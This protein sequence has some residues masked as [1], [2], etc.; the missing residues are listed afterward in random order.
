MVALPVSH[1]KMPVKRLSPRLLIQWMLAVAVSLL[2]VFSGRLAFAAPPAAGTSIGNQASATYTDGSGVNRT[3]TSNTVQTVVQ[4]VASLT[5]TANGAKSA[6]VGSTVYYPHTLTNTGNGVD[7]FGLSAVNA[8][9][10][11]F[12]LTGIAIFAD[13]GAGLPT[14][15]AI[16]S[17]GAIT[18]GSTFKFIV[19]GTV[20]STATSGSTNNLTVTAESGFSPAQTAT[21]TDTTTVTGNAVINFTKSVSANSGASG[22]GPYTYTLT[23]TNTGNSTATVVKVTDVIPA[24]LTYVASSA[25]SSVLPVGVVLTDAIDGSQGTAPNTIAYDFTAGTATATLAQV[26]SGQSGTISFQVNVTGGTAP[27]V[28]N[29]TATVSYNDGSAAGTTITGTS[30]TVPFSVTQSASVTIGNSTV[31][32]GNPGTA[33]LFTN[34]VTNTGNGTDTFNITVSPGNFPPGT[35][36]V[37]YKS[38]GVTPLVDTNGDGILDTGPLPAGA[39]AASTYNVVVKAVLPATASGGPFTVNVTATSTFDPTKS[40]TGVD[41]LTAVTASSVDLTNNAAAGV[42]GALGTG[43]GP[44]AAAQ[45]TNLT[46][47]GSSTTFILVTKNTGP[48][49]DSYGLAASTDSSFASQTL[50]A[51][52]TVAFRADGG[53]GNCTTTIGGTITTT[54]SVAANASSVVCAAVSVPAGFA[55]GTS[56]LYFRAL[57]ASSGAL[58]RI[59]DAVTVNAVRSLTFTPNN[60]GQVFP[61]GSVVYSHT[62]R[63]TGNVT[64]GNGTLS[65][66]TLPSANSQPGFTSVQY[67]DSNNNGVLDAGDPVVPAGGLQTVLVAGLP[68]GQAITIFDKVIAPSGAAA[69]VVNTTTVT[70]STANGTNPGTKPADA[71]ATDSSTVI[72]GNVTLTKTQRLNATCSAANVGSYSTATLTTGA[73]PGVCIDYQITVQNLGSA[74]ATGVTVSDATPA[75]TVLALAPATTAGTITP[76]TPAVGASGS[77]TATI[78]PL[79]AGASAVVTF[80]VKIQP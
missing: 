34:A 76:P 75:F 24:G 70:A 16:T 53:A 2:L 17:T 57:S 62:L 79:A 22:S 35:S 30:N 20:P 64:E 39:T 11:S 51:G 28:V 46:N 44:E 63:N 15:P 12:N 59:H 1:L 36:F 13:N 45:V 25:R 58:D 69:G 37:L 67:Y 49:A 38:D 72:S 60:T 27:G 26:A 78:G 55:A 71:A 42:A 65:T 74:D 77:I 31:A 47:P 48:V 9:G 40:A 18:S 19:A 21:N 43:A 10:A 41:T 33:V 3:V 61:G 73:V 32:S 66:I 52:W 50:P 8:A 14:G 6:S 23:Y 29:N 56:D 4:Q 5:L 80:A 7:T 54:P 68:P